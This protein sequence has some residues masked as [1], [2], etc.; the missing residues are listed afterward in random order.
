VVGKASRGPGEGEKGTGVFGKAAAINRKKKKRNWKHTDREH[1]NHRKKI[2]PRSLL[3]P[4]RKRGKN[5]RREWSH[6]T[7]GGNRLGKGTEEPYRERGDAANGPPRSERL[8]CKKKKRLGPKGKKKKAKKRG[9]K[10]GK[11]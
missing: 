5:A 3:N 8:A 9:A 2:P 10:K 7:K 1:D 11:G 6:Q 4:E